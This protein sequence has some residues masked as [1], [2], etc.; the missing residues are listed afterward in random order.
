M[1]REMVRAMILVGISVSFTG[2]VSSKPGTREEGAS[3]VTPVAQLS[4]RL[5]S[6]PDG[7][8]FATEIQ[9]RLDR[10]DASVSVSWPCGDNT[11][12]FRSVNYPHAFLR[13]EDG[14]LKLNDYQDNDLFRNDA[15]F[16]RVNGLAEMASRS[17][18]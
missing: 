11:M 7:L 9:S 3:R 1:T 6:A 17:N 4:K 14:R 12:S 2:L 18:R 16:R 10:K 5:H 15:S 8:G 13:H